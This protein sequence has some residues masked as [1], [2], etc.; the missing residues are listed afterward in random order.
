MVYDIKKIREDFPVLNQIIDGKPPIY[1]DNACMSLKPK[2]VIEAMNEYYFNHPGCHK[3]AIHKFGKMTTLRY[4]RA[5]EAVQKFINARDS[6]EIIFT[7][8]T[9]EGINLVANSFP[10]K[11]GDVIL[12]TELEHNS[13]FLPWQVLSTKKGVVH[14][15]FPLSQDLTFDLEKFKDVLSQEIKLVSIFHTSH[16]SG[17]TLPIEEIIRL[18]HQYGALVLV[19]G[20]QSISCQK[21]DVQKLDADFFAFSF[22]KMLGPTGMGALYA[23]RR[24]LENMQPFLIGGETVDDVDYGFFI[25]S[26]IPDRFESGLQNYAGAMGAEAAIRYLTNIGIEQI[27]EHQLKLNEFI[28]DEILKF[29]KIKLLGSKDPKLR[30]G[31]INFYIEGMDSGELSIILDQTN[32]IMTR[33]GLHCCHAWYKKY[34][35]PPTLRASVYFYNSI[36]EA[37][38]FV[39]TLKKIIKYF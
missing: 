27:E 38:I 16:I 15:T 8:N 25:L 28:T 6:G 36:E 10:F 33:S 5:R 24:L 37:Q 14:R 23:K 30:A 35:L 29:S 1:F 32:N 13:N 21:I 39:Q 17:Y 7:R 2:Q 3:R 12:S 9:T 4:K 26:E 19:D 34:K 11:K 20:A 22:H 18:S 31:I